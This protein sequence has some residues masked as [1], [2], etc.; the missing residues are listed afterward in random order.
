MV[1]AIAI[2]DLQKRTK[3]KERKLKDKN[4]KLRMINLIN[5][6]LLWKKASAKL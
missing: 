3:K 6:V 2:D 4:I 5:F 1:K